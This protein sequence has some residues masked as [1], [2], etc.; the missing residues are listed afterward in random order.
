M[1]PA[2]HEASGIRVDFVFSATPY[3]QEAISRA[4]VV[5]LAGASVPFT[6]AE[7]LII[8]KLFALPTATERV[9]VP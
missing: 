5:Y 9:C 7:D 4:T 6:S 3:E 1:L 8:H 2:H